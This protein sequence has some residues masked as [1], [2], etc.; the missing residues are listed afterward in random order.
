MLQI[1][2]ELVKQATGTP[3][4][5]TGNEIACDAKVPKLLNKYFLTINLELVHPN[6][7]TNCSFFQI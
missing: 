2:V 3:Q 6:Q 4:D 7:F 1:A 5:G